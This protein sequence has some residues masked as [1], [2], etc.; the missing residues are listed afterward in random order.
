MSWLTQG[1]FKSC[2]DPHQKVQDFLSEYSKLGRIV[3]DAFNAVDPLHC[4]YGDDCNPDE[5]LGYAKRFISRLC[6]AI[7][8][9][10]FNDP[11]EYV[12]LVEGS[13]H[14]GQREEG[15]L[16]QDDIYQI[17]VQIVEGMEQAYKL[18]LH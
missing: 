8:E 14:P 16:D 3:L 15:F 17:A 7:C 5:Y 1:G 9:G 13:F 6:D 4:Y 2:Y 11:L 18:S 10:S 12:S